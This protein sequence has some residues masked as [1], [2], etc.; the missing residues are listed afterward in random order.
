MLRLYLENMPPLGVLE[1][2][3][4]QWGNVARISKRTLR[5]IPADLKIPPVYINQN[6]S[7]EVQTSGLD[8]FE[9]EDCVERLEHWLG[10][11]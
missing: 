4:G 11:N 3:L 2:R 5:L 9:E 1:Q 7:I 8:L 10:V 6:G